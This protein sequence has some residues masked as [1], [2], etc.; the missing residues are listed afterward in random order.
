M[1]KYPT[2][3]WNL[4]AGLLWGGMQ[5]T[6]KP[7]KKALEKSSARWVRTTLDEVP[8]EP[9]NWIKLVQ[10]DR[11]IVLI[12]LEIDQPAWLLQATDFI[13]FHPLASIRIH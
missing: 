8:T 4:G 13:I 3:L 7:P 5:S 11:Q 9:P 2:N 10:I 1:K 6:T 12:H